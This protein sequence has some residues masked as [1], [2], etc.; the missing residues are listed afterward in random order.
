MPKKLNKI[1]MDKIIKTIIPKDFHQDSEGQE[2]KVCTF[3]AKSLSETEPYM[4]EKNFKVN[5][6][7]KI[8]STA[9]EYAICLPCSIKKMNA[10]SKESTENIK[11]YMQENVF[12][13]LMNEQFL[14]STFEE[15]TKHCA[16]TGKL[17]VELTEYSLVGQFIG[18]Q[19]ILKE[20]PIV[21]SSEIGEEM[22]NLL[23]EQT[24]KEF[25]DFMDTITGIPPELK[26]LFKTKRPILV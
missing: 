26:S 19:M 23:S 2:F 15:K 8:K 18:N 3:C 9:F 20:F 5:P 22:Q 4:I 11:R 12:D 21:V 1:T 16:V 13:E 14:K 6:F 24:K 25:D 7:N 17:R 10:M